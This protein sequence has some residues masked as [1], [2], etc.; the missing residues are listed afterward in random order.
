MSSG[1]DYIVDIAGLRQPEPAE[2][3]ATLRGRPWVAVRW[4]CCEAYTRIYRNR[5]GTAY[6]GRCPSCSR[7]VRFLIGEGGTDHRFFEA[8]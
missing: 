4:R 7:P 1:P 6:E 8:T 2:P 3:G 5:E